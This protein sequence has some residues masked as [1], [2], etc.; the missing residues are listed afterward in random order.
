MGKLKFN[1]GDKVINK[2]ESESMGQLWI[3]RIIHA[4]PQA[5]DFE[6]LKVS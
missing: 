4:F 5:W 1:V 3:Y 6:R 2:K